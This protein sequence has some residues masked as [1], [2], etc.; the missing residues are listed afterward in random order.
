MFFIHKGQ[1]ALDHRGGEFMGENFMLGQIL[2]ELVEKNVRFAPWMEE[3][4]RNLLVQ[5]GSRGVLCI[6][7]TIELVGKTLN[8]DD[9]QEAC[10]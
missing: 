3:N 5:T 8:M 9:K 1:G 10:K 6:S 7:S 4:V 2:K